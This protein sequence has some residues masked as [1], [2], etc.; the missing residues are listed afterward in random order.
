MDFYGEIETI[1]SKM[2]GEKVKEMNPHDH[3]KALES[4]I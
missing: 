1:F 4:G 3:K 2:S